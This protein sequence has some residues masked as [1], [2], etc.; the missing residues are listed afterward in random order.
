MEHFFYVRTIN[1]IVL[2]NVQ[3]NARHFL[4]TTFK[5]TYRQNMFHANYFHNKLLYVENMS[6][7]NNRQKKRLL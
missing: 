7:Q 6:K 2:Y 5:I 1:C 4:V 3:H